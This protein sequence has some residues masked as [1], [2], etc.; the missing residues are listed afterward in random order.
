M[1]QSV[2]FTIGQ[3][4]NA[5]PI[6]ITT[7]AMVNDWIRVIGKCFCNYNTKTTKS[8]YYVEKNE[9]DTKE[10]DEGYCRDNCVSSMG[11]IIFKYCRLYDLKNYYDEWICMLPLKY[12][13]EEN[14]ILIKY[15]C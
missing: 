4:S 10:I 12:D 7:E 3:L 13:Q 2:A 5:I 8:K 6:T 15:F 14:Q 9:E 1:R 11:K